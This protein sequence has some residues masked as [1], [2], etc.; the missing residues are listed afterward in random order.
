[1]GVVSMKLPFLN[2]ESE[3]ARLDAAFSAATSSFVCLYGRRRCGKSRLLLELLP[4]L[5]AVYYVAD[6]RD[7]NIQRRALAKEIGR[8]IPGFE[9]VEYPEWPDLLERWYTDAP[10]GSVLVIDE[11]PFLVSASPELPSVMQKIMDKAHEKPVHIAVCGS[12]QRMMHGLVLDASAPLYGRAAEILK[13]QP[14]APFYLTSILSEASP[15]DWI[16]AWAFWGG[17]PRYWELALE[18]DPAMSAITQLVLD[19]MGVLHHEPRRLLTDELIEIRQAASILSLI[20][21]GCRR[22]SEIAGRIGRPATSLTRPLALLIDMGLVHRETPFNASHRDTKRSLYRIADPFLQFWFTFVE[23]N[24][25]LLQ[26]GRMEL[27]AKG[28]DGKLPAYIGHVWEELARASVPKIAI[29]E[30][31]WH[32][33]ST[34][35]GKGIDGSPLEIDIIARSFSDP[36]HF[37]CG[38]VKASADPG[39]IPALVSDLKHRAAQCPE[40]ARKKISYALWIIE[41]PAFD[42]KECELIDA[43]TVFNALR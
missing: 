3:K 18:N 1:M 39:D 8:L 22:L 42:V 27:V 41:A 9:R 29:R 34:W 19:P 32:P 40:I 30:T 4:S 13:I 25:S 31:D 17:I 28:I 37:L 12:S 26:A 24:T 15:H 21:Q 38:E 35:W 23:P 36:N 6:E 5:T 20:G 16:R 14:L 33:A 11:L 10:A 7:A 43:K 2:R